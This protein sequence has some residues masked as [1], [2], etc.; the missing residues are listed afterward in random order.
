MFSLFRSTSITGLTP[1]L[2][3]IALYPL[4]AKVPSLSTTDT[5]PLSLDVARIQ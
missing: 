3:L 2:V 5:Y 4:S 1:T